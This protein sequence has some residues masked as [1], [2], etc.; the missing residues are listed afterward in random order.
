MG[1]CTGNFPAAV[2]ISKVDA[3]KEIELI[4]VLGSGTVQECGV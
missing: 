2:Q 3:G 4:E 1:R